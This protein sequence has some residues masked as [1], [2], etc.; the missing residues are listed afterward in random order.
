MLFR[1]AGYSSACA[2]APGFIDPD[3]DNYEL[4]R[5]E[6]CGTDSLRT[7]GEK[8]KFGSRRRSYAELARY[9]ARRA[10]AKTFGR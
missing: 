9:Y 4:K 2:T 5:I 8:L 1:S 7:F 6:V 3:G 10:V